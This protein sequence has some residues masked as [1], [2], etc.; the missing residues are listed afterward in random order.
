MKR[1]QHQSTTPFPLVFARHQRHNYHQRSFF[2]QESE[3][4]NENWSIIRNDASPFPGVLIPAQRLPV[5]EEIKKIKLLP[6]ENHPTRSE[7]KHILP[8]NRHEVQ[9]IFTIFSNWISLKSFC[10]PRDVG[11][12]RQSV[13]VGFLGGNG[14]SLGSG[15]IF[16]HRNRVARW[17]VTEKFKKIINFRFPL[18][19]LRLFLTKHSKFK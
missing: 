1:T 13:G 7:N 6:T 11:H 3:K 17:S 16:F 19:V 14:W 12:A 9:K 10:C 18:K 4:G 15:R 2:R 5:I 8:S